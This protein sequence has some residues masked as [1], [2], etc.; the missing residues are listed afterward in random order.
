MQGWSSTVAPR[1]RRFL[2]IEVFTPVSIIA[3]VGPSLP[4]TPLPSG[5]SRISSDGVTSRARSRPSIDGSAAISAR[6]SSSATLAGKRPP[7]IAPWSRMWRT[8]ARVS[9]S[10][11]PGIPCSRSQSSQPCSA[12]GASERFVAAR[13]IAARACGADDSIAA[14]RDAVV[15][16][17]GG[18]ERDQLAGEGGIGH[19]LLVAGHAGR[20]D[21]LA[22]GVRVGAAGDPVEA[23]TV[24]QQ[25]VGGRVVHAVTPEAVGFVAG[26]R[27]ATVPAATVSRTTPSKVRP[28]K[29]ELA[30]R[31]T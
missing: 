15:A 30:E 17:V 19:R 14:S 23:L 24:L 31:L 28:K 2:T 8:S 12:P 18:R 26:A 13:M 6:A 7:R 20:E 16:D 3:I 21:D 4:T 11:I 27:W 5:S 9:R 29:Q 10:V 22:D 25:D 1:S